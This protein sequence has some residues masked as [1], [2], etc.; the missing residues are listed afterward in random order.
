MSQ[1]AHKSRAWDSK[2]LSKEEGDTMRSKILATAILAVSV[3]GLAACGTTETER[4]LT[5][6]GIGG[7]AGYA[8]G[9]PVAGAV[10]G[11]ATGVFTDSDDLNLGEPIWDQW[12]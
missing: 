6:A 11:G 4:G 7:A 9:A 1:P 8:V 3:A 5:G 12:D 2:L 10:A